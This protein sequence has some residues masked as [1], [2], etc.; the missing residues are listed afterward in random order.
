MAPIT[1]AGIIF[2]SVAVVTLSTGRPGGIPAVEKAATASVVSKPVVK[3]RV[4]TVTGKD[5]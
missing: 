5:F 4:V 2:G 1:V 3:A